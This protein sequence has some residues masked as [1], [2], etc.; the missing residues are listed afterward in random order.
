M[1]KNKET[2]DR[3]ARPYSAGENAWCVAAVDVIDDVAVV[4]VEGALTVRALSVCRGA[5]DQALVARPHAVI[6][7]LHG[8]G[9]AD[10]AVPV[11]G[12]IRRYIHRHGIPLW[13]V[14]APTTVVEALSTHGVVELYRA[15]SSVPAAVEAAA[16]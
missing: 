15:A 9:Q 10:S 16:P 4:T 7:D 5:V 6:L 8:V 12:L 2:S 13:L 1:R 11:L 14:A 3:G